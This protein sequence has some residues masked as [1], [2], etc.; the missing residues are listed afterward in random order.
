MRQLEGGR[1]IREA[2]LPC[3]IGFCEGGNVHEEELD[4]GQDDG[5]QDDGGRGEGGEVRQKVA[6]EG[7]LREPDDEQGECY[8]CAEG[9]QGAAELKVEGCGEGCFRCFWF[10]L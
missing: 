2:V 10:W 8:H 7:R 3:G 5:G 1:P 4:R 6:M 9:A